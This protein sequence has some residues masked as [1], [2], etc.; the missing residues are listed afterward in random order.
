[1]N[2]SFATLLSTAQ[3]S[4]K[5]RLLW[6]VMSA[7][8]ITDLSAQL[9]SL[10]K[11]PWLGYFAAYESS[12]FTVGLST[13]GEIKVTP[14]DQKGNP[15][16]PFNYIMVNFGIEEVLPEGKSEMKKIKA[17]TLTSEQAA[18]DKLEKVVIRGK[19]SAD[20]GFEAAI[21]QDRGVISITG[22]VTDTGMFKKNPVR[23]GVQVKIPDTYPPWMREDKWKAD[24]KAM[25]ALQ[26]T[27]KMDNIKLVWADGKKVSQSFEKAVDAASK[28][29]TGPGVVKAEIEVGAYRNRKLLFSASE[30]SVMLLSNKNPSPLCD[31]F[32]IH[33]TP[34]A[35]GKARFSFEIK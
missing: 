19:V 6:F 4:R 15:F 17:E 32:L 31:G 34:D 25:A 28:E 5:V 33:W 3:T 23:F 7:S 29:I 18:T 24:E 20:A 27:I 16:G 1:M 22:H 9:P 2:P 35:G 26:K 8:C 13:T 12:R 30:P 10:G 11:A 14:L 21:E